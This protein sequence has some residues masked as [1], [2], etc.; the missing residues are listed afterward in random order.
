MKSLVM[1][2]EK[3]DCNSSITPAPSGPEE[4]ENETESIADDVHYGQLI[5]SLPDLARTVRPDI[6]FVVCYL[7]LFRN[8]TYILLRK[9]FKTRSTL[10]ES[11][12]SI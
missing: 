12:S 8:R 2:F 1:N 11:E 5:R 3:N 7:S 6:A 4:N 9:A 10:F